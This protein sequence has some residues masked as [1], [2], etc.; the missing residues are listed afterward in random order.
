MQAGNHSV[1][2]V[3]KE[4]SHSFNPVNHE[5]VYIC[6]YLCPPSQ[7]LYHHF[8][9]F[10]LLWIQTLVYIF[11]CVCHSAIL[12]IVICLGVRIRVTFDLNGIPKQKQMVSVN[13]VLLAERD[14]SC[15]LGSLLNKT[16][17]TAGAKWSVLTHTDTNTM[18]VNLIEGSCGS[19]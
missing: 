10:L 19:G 8:R 15:I 2:Y 13:C 16:F 7:P 6:I 18:V 17:I 12:R 14:P 4:V 5:N 11:V 3:Y 1:V 9:E